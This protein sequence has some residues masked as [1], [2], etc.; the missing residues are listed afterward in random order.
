MIDQ[1]KIKRYESRERKLLM[2]E[3]K[4]QLKPKKFTIYDQYKCGFEDEKGYKYHLVLTEPNS[5][6]KCDALLFKLRGENVIDLLIIEVKVRDKEYSEWKIER[7]K[8]EGV[9]DLK[10]IFIQR[11]NLDFK[12]KTALLIIGFNDSLW[13]KIEDWWMVD[14][15]IWEEDK[16]NACTAMNRD[17]KKDRLTYKLNR[18]AA[19]RSGPTKNDITIE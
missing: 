15:R 7:T 1:E 17:D 14:D 3:I 2:R 6:I 19:K 11:H 12:P 8:M 13:F 16:L 9:I 5:K 18:F 4:H 10:K